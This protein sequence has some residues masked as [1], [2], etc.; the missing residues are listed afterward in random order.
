[1]AFGE[2]LADAMHCRQWL[3]N[4][5]GRNGMLTRTRA[6][7]TDFTIIIPKPPGG[8]N[9]SFHVGDQ[10]LYPPMFDKA[11]SCHKL[12]TDER[13]RTNA[14]VLLLNLSRSTS[15]VQAMRVRMSRSLPCQGSHS[16]SIHRGSFDVKLC[17]SL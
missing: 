3:R 1:M 16:C 9:R 4:F 15:R 17:R 5:P 11:D 14:E 13:L 10:P 6:L 7:K 8:I 12:E 2:R